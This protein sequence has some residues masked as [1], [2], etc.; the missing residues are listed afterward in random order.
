MN[1]INKMGGQGVP[2]YSPNKAHYNS[3]DCLRVLSCLGIML[4]HIQANTEYHL[5]GNFF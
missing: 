4:M 1:G 2:R 3:I 5:S